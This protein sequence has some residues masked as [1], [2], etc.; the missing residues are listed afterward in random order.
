M[1]DAWNGISTATHLLLNDLARS[2]GNTG[3]TAPRQLTKDGCLASTRTA[4][5]DIQAVGR[6]LIQW[7]G[8]CFYR[9]KARVPVRAYLHV[10]VSGPH[11]LVEGW[12]RCVERSMHLC[13][14]FLGARQQ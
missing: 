9:P 11:L 14:V 10:G 2:F 4:C 13:V 1:S 8:Q 5:D 3:E 12:L 6:L 7:T